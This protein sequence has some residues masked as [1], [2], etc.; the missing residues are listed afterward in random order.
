[1]A[2]AAKAVRQTGGVTLLSWLSQKM[3]MCADSSAV[4]STAGEDLHVEADHQR[5][6][7]A[8]SASS[9]PAASGSASAG[10]ARQLLR[11]ASI[12][13]ARGR[14]GQRARGDQLD[15]WPCSHQVVERRGRQRAS[16]I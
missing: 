13:M 16:T 1:M 15:H 6:V 10:R 3:I 5:S 9:R 4:I 14:L 7:E 2:A 11:A 12:S 8:R